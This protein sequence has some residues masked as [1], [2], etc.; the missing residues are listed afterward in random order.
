VEVVVLGNTITIRKLA[1]VSRSFQKQLR[2]T[3]NTGMVIMGSGVVNYLLK[4][5]VIGTDRI[6]FGTLL[7]DSPICAA[8]MI[9]DSN[10]FKSWT[11]DG[12]LGLS[13]GNANRHGLSTP[14]YPAQT[15]MKNMYN[16]SFNYS[17]SVSFQYNKKK[18]YSQ[19]TGGQITYKKTSSEVGQILFGT[20][21][22]KGKG[23][24]LITY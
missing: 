22:G 21:E 24:P 6:Q 10:S 3:L 23:N 1:K 18:L 4:S 7:V 15:F 19:N 8:N 11:Y 16:T 2:T 5:D 9:K 14:V 13:P 12:I 20:L 17:N